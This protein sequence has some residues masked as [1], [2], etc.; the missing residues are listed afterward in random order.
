MEEHFEALLARKDKEIEELKK[1][2]K[3]LLAVALKRAKACQELSEK[4]AAKK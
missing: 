4:L 1:E 2:N 3:L